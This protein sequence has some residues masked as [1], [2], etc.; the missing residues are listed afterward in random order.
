MVKV[1][2]VPSLAAGEQIAITLTARHTGAL[3]FSVQ[4]TWAMHDGQMARGPWG[5]ATSV[6]YEYNLPL[7]FR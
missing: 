3:P 7:L 2:N 1:F 4:S 5:E 6:A